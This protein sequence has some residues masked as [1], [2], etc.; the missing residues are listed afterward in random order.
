[1]AFSVDQNLKASGGITC[2]TGVPARGD[3]D[4]AEK[5]SKQADAFFFVFLAQIAEEILRHLILFNLYGWRVVIR[6]DG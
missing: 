1:M 5:L 3:E 6:R 4:T 2:L